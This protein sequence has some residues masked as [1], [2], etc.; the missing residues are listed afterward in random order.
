[1][2]LF[3]YGE[4]FITFLLIIALSF[5]LNILY[6]KLLDIDECVI[7]NPCDENANCI[8]RQG[9]FDCQCNDG[10]SGDGVNNCESMTHF[11]C[12]VILHNQNFN[13]NCMH[14]F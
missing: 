1:M 7:N 4:V 13:L 5:Y 14:C 10:F 11:F 9:S 3:K 12:I 8:D 2:D 6:L